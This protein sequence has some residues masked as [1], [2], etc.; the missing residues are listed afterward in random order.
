MN[1]F[2]HAVAADWVNTSAAFAY[3]AMLPDLLQM[4]GVR[5]LDC[6]SEHVWSGIHFHHQTD[7]VFH[8]SATFA[9]LETWA[10]GRLSELGVRKGPRRALSHVGLE[11]LLDAVLARTPAHLDAYHR[12]LE[13]G[14]GYQGL[15]LRDTAA[16]GAL[17]S[18][19]QVLRE[20]ASRLVPNDAEALADRLERIL[21]RRPK[22]SF[23]ASERPH[24]VAFGREAGELVE[25]R[26]PSWVSEL[27]AS[28]APFGSSRLYSD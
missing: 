8:E 6:D 11:L 16:Q 12:A 5:L 22:L 4:A 25:A 1:F 17:G 26:A 24:V 2:G 9:E 18:L 27:R 28:I 19:C 13:F 20:R 3:G 10:R 7:R 23:D 14:Q 15:E 21:Q